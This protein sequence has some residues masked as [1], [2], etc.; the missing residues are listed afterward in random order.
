[1]NVLIEL[2]QLAFVMAVTVIPVIAMIRL[3]AGHEDFGFDALVRSDATLV[4][5][6]GVQEEEPR[7]WRFGSS[8]A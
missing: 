5:P 2:V 1:M 4:W 3:F 6:M 7:P 8:A